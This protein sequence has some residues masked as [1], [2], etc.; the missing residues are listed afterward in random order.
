MVGGEL[1]V[2]RRLRTAISSSMG[3]EGNE[4]RIARDECENV[5]MDRRLRWREYCFCWCGMTWSLCNHYSYPF[6]AA[7]ILGEREAEEVKWGRLWTR[8]GPLGCFAERGTWTVGPG[9][10]GWRR[11]EAGLGGLASFAR[12]A[13]CRLGRY[14]CARGG[15]L[16]GTGGA[17]AARDR[18]GRVGE[19]VRPDAAAGRLGRPTGGVDSRRRRTMWI[20]CGVVLFSSSGAGGADGSGPRGGRGREGGVL[21]LGVGWVSRCP[22]PELLHRGVREGGRVFDER[23]A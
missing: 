3:N 15:R 13:A 9:S 23:R 18:R 6:A 16:R 7:R 14:A 22:R 21:T 10:A 17:R 5:N 11:V 1:Y 12:L 2:C 8:W 20:V 4:V 19:R